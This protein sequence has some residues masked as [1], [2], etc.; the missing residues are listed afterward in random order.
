MW[1]VDDSARPLTRPLLCTQ[2]RIAIAAARKAALLY[3]LW[4]CHMVRV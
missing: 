4:S 1:G 2:L 3:C